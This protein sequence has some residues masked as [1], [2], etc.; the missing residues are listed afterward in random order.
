MSAA[1]ALLAAFVLTG[2]AHADDASGEVRANNVWLP[3]T[4]TP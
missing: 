1:V 4:T 3:D 2:V